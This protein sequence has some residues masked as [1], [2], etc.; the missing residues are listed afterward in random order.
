MVKD[1]FYSHRK[2]YD[3]LHGFIR[4]DDVIKELIDTLLFQR[5]HYIHQ[6]GISYLVYPGA[7]H[8]RFEHSLGVMELATRIFHNICKHA[9]PDVFPIVP[10]KGSYEYL[11]WMKI[12]RVA[13][14][15]HDMGH[16]PFSHVAE[17]D[18]LGDKGH[19]YITEQLIRSEYLAPVWEK[20][21]AETETFYPGRDVVDDIVKLS[22]GEKSSLKGSFS[23]WEKILSQIIV[24][25][26]FGADR[27]DYLLRD[28]KST[29]VGYGIFDYEQLIEMIRILPVPEKDDQDLALGINEN[30]LEACEALL[31]ARHF[32]HRRV[33]QYASVKAYNFHLRRFMRTIYTPKQML[34]LDKFI[35]INDTD[36]IAKL[37]IAAQDSSHPG[38]EDA[39]RIIVR[40]ERFKAIPSPKEFQ[41]EDFAS[42]QEKLGIEGTHFSWESKAPAL[43][44]KALAFPVSRRHL[45]V[46]K[47][48]DCSELLCK[49]QA[50]Q[51]G[52]LYFAPEHEMAILEYLHRHG[53]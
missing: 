8:T 20:L 18:L 47:A 21:R 53:S 13:A 10:R 14:L 30:G 19:E 39:R 49:V 5:L 45:M 41:A 31:L 52:W 11:Y 4:F 27:I 25:D 26:F 48:N 24:G 9:R 38:H 3:S 37:S 16:L 12:L 46:E 32:M 43:P 50:Y 36:V 15:C 33:Y 42:M 17:Q 29:G 34:D 51:T 22:I 23:N 35:Y 6:L 7:T 28:S 44:E 40:K 1:F 2:I